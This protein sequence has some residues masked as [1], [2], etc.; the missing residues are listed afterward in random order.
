[1]NRRKV[2]KLGVWVL[3]FVF[4]FCSGP[5]L[6]DPAVWVD[7]S[8][9]RITV[10]A[11]RDQMKKI[12]EMLP[13]FP[14]QTRQIQIEAKIIEVSS[15]VT[16]K[17]GTFL[18][19]ITE[20]GTQEMGIDIGDRTVRDVFSKGLKF[21][22]SRLTQEEQFEAILNALLTQDKARIL[23]APR[24]VT[25]SGEVAG[26]YVTTEVPYYAG[27]TYREIGGEVISE[28]QYEYASVGVVLQVLPRIVGE[29][30]V[31]MS[32]VP[33]VGDYE[34]TAQFGPQHPIFKRQV[35]PT[36]VTIKDGESL[37]IGGLITKDRTKT[38]IG[39]PVISHLPIIGN[40]FKSQ[41]DIVEEKNLIVI[42]K[43]H[44]LKQREIKG[45]VKKVFHFQYALASEIEPQIRKVISSDGS[46]QVNPKEA[47]P[48]SIIVREREDKI[49]VIQSLLNEIGSYKTQERQGVYHLTYTDVRDARE[50][51]EDFLSSRGSVT[52]DKEDN[53]LIVEDG[54][55]QLSMID[56]VISTLEEH[57]AEL[58]SRVFQLS[59]LPADL[60][61]EKIR[62]ILSP[63]GSVQVVNG[64]KILVEDG[65]WAL[66][67]VRERLEQIDTFEKQKKTRI[68]SLKHISP[69]ELVE[70][71]NFDRE[72]KAILSPEA[73]LEVN[74]KKN[75]LVITALGWKHEKI[76]ELIG[77]FDQFRPVEFVYEAQF[78][79]VDLLKSE[80]SSLLSPQGEISIDTARNSLIIKDS[81]RRVEQIKEKLYNLDVAP[82]VKKKRE[83]SVNYIPLEK[84][85]EMVQE[86]MSSEGD[87]IHIDRG[88]QSFVIKD[89]PSALSRIER[90]LAKLDTFEEQKVARVYNLKYVSAE[91]AARV[92][93]YFLS[94]AGK[95]YTNEYKVL[96]I[97][98]PH[99]QK[100]VEKIINLINIPPK[101]SQL[102]Y[103][104]QAFKQD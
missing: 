63:R 101:F 65:N 25:M 38:T 68:Y 6:A 45:R 62:P 20:V 102:L 73:E 24:V 41:T 67:K 83:I 4:L 18:E 60:A 15:G 1:M 2:R 51:I 17:F 59:Y 3:L 71:D 90:K 34:I 77:K 64:R 87:I 84:A 30:L 31:E 93:R 8:T 100:Q 13:Q 40:L 48:N 5:L 72:L 7:P 26:V 88:A 78:V 22:F 47:P 10:R 35:S 21:S 33:L 29:D 27:T 96:V 49:R 91:D 43:P 97:D 55:Y 28:E 86:E 50:A 66:R 19:K 56:R 23:S 54:A 95:V 53:T 69:S 81:P 94:P 9:G 99:Y 61:R 85:L 42:I 14:V 57:N 44:I 70:L 92:I 80:V 89:T 52:V 58:H 16:E 12:E 79:S 32:I 103:F 39:V 36:N 75:Q 74:D 37:V 11:S 98:V 46:I 104:K 76:E 82:G